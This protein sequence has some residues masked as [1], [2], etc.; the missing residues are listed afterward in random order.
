MPLLEFLPVITLWIGGQSYRRNPENINC[1]L[2]AQNRPCMSTADMTDGYQLM[3]T[4]VKF[5]HVDGHYIGVHGNKVGKVEFDLATAK[6][7]YEEYKTNGY[8]S[9]NEYNS[10]QKNVYVVSPQRTCNCYEFGR[11]FKCPHATCVKILIDKIDVPDAAKTIPLSCR[12]KAGRPKKALERYEIQDYGVNEVINYQLSSDGADLNCGGAPSRKKIK[13]SLPQIAFTLDESSQPPIP[14]SEDI[15]ISL[16]RL[17]PESSRFKIA[18][19]FLPLTVE[20]NI[21]VDEVL[22]STNS[23]NEEIANN[24]QISITKKMIRTLC[25]DEWLISFT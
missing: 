5:Y 25:T 22:F 8:T 17:V 9:M 14:I 24:Y 23:P 18:Q 12:R 10:F 13:I 20:E 19:R 3:K 11:K 1:L 16:P 4:M 21:A 2:I 6:K 7:I 15:P